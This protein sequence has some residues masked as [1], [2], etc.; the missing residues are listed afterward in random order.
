[1][2]TKNHTREVGD[3]KE[4]YSTSGRGSYSSVNLYYRDVTWAVA[5]RMESFQILVCFQRGIYRTCNGLKG[6]LKI[7]SCQINAIGLRNLP[8]RDRLNL[9]I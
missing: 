5:V 2:F 3:S 7:L 9:S 1:M 8:N 6:S 4:A